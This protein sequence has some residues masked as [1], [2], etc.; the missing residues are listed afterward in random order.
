MGGSDSVIDFT[1]YVSRREGT[2]DGPAE[3]DR[4]FKEEWL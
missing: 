2:Q 3:P 1:Q 4:V